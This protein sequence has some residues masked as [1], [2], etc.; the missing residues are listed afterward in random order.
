MIDRQI[1]MSLILN[2][3]ILFV[4]FLLAEFNCLAVK[5]GGGG[6]GKTYFLIM[7]FN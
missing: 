4:D 3:Y 7:Y 5:L 1:N 2:T 6:S